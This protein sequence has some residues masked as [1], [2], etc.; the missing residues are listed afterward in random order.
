MALS[1]APED[2]VGAGADD[3]T[4]VTVADDP[5]GVAG[6]DS[7]VE[8]AGALDEAATGPQ[9]KL[10]G[11]DDEV[12]AEGEGAALG[13][14]GFPACI[15]CCCAEKVVETIG[16]PTPGPFRFCKVTAAALRRASCE[17][18]ELEVGKERPTVGLVTTWPAARFAL[19][20][21]MNKSR[22]GGHEHGIFMGLPSAPFTAP[23]QSPEPVGFTP[24]CHPN[25]GTRLGSTSRLTGRDATDAT[26][27]AR[28]GARTVGHFMLAGRA[29]DWSRERMFGCKERGQGSKSTIDESGRPAR[30]LR[31]ESEVSKERRA[32]TVGVGRSSRKEEKGKISGV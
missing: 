9:V 32:D 27:T 17:A 20:S 12:E 29:L 31:C 18:V 7:R 22:S 1:D 28:K 10:G 2:D 5:A 13:G 23:S 3:S 25:W 4:E 6:A 19:R 26:S 16:Q 15:A 24:D 8:V 11:S 21:L 30:F 14:R